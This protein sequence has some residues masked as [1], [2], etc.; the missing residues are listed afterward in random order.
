MHKP[1]TQLAPAG[2]HALRHLTCGLGQGA[3]QATPGTEASAA[4]TKALASILSALRR[5]TS[6]LA[7]PLARLS[8]DTSR[9]VVG[10]W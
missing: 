6:P 2:Q 1:E 7:R 8:K 5:D 9:E 4:P 10:S 3:A